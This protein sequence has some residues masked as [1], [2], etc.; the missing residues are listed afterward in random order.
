MVCLYT[1]KSQ[2]PAPGRL[3]T[4]GRM[5]IRYTVLLLSHVRQRQSLLAKTQ[6]PLTAS[7]I[8]VHSCYYVETREV[9]T[10]G[11][12][13]A[14]W[15]RRGCHRLHR[16]PATGQARHDYACIV[17]CL[18]AAPA[19]CGGTA[20][21][22]QLF[23]PNRVVRNRGILGRIHTMSCWAACLAIY[24]C[25]H[26]GLPPKAASITNCLRVWNYF[27]YIYSVKQLRDA[28]IFV[29]SSSHGRPCL[30]SVVWLG[31][32]RQ[33]EVCRCFLLSS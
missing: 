2:L 7:G 30:S 8:S 31:E 17:L 6:L 25:L 22:D 21:Y 28:T 15:Q 32:A 20:R 29:T 24:N 23:V 14:E 18:A 4:L 12:P 3:V 10:C 27:K 33:I 1:R 26:D 16:R 11:C 5:I 9:C 19:R 13:L